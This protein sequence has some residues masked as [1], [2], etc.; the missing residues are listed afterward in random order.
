MG[1]KTLTP[2]SFY[3]SLLSVLPRPLGCNLIMLFPVRLEQFGDIRDKRVIRVGISEEGADGEEDFRNG[4]GGA[5]VVFE[6]I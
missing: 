1:S 6:N 2:A 4:Q 5:P 3:P